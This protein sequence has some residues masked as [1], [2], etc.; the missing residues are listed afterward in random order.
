MARTAVTV[1]EWTTE[2]SNAVVL[3]SAGVALDPTNGHVIT[4]PADCDPRDLLVFVV[5]TTAT[6]KDVTVKAG[7]NPP[8]VRSGAG[9]LVVALGDGS[10]A[11]VNTFIPLGGGSRFM[12]ADGTIYVDVEASATGR[13]AC[14]RV[15]RN[16]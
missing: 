10:T 8:A 2:A 15:P 13:I 9:D 4:P 14:F 3:A 1:T 6:E 16:D 5:H 12:Q 11:S 7:A